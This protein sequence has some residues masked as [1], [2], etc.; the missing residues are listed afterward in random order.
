MINKRKKYIKEWID[1]FT[2]EKEFRYSHFHIDEIC[3]AYEHKEKWIKAGV[4]C[5]KDGLN[6]IRKGKYDLDIALLIDLKSSENR[7]NNIFNNI[8]EIEKEFGDTPPSIYISKKDHVVVS[9]DLKLRQLDIFNRPVKN[10]KC[11]YC[12]FKDDKDLEYTRFL[13]FNQ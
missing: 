1:N 12:E 5:L 6:F 4:K 11:Y 10:I 3:I 9:E 13:W 2:G 7:K 8:A